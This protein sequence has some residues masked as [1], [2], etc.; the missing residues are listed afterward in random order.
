[1]YHFFYD[2]TEHSRKINY[3]TITAS[4]YYDNFINSTNY[5]YEEM[6]L[7]KEYFKNFNADNASEIEN[8]VHYFEN[9]ADKVLHNS[10]NYL[11]RD[12]IPPIDRE[13]IIN[14]LHQLDDVVD[15]VDEIAIDVN[16]YNIEHLRDDINEY[17]ELLEQG[18]ESLVELTKKMK[19]AKSRDDIKE[20]IV[21]IN[22][23]ED[24][25]DKL[26][27]ASMKELYK[28]EKDA[29]EVNKWTIIYSRLEDCF[30][31]LEDVSDYIDEIVMKNT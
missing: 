26:F 24:D 21:T 6:K 19:I 2:E 9:E 18:V 4:N 23:I 30:D 15:C 12:F 22:N 1:M 31:R 27:Q 20:L 3:Q 28:N 8:K 29:I 7:I 14:L 25:G 5:A 10:L 17:M 11:V 13:D 16:I